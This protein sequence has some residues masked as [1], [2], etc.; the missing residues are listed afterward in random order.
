MPAKGSGK[1]FRVKTGT[2]NLKPLAF[3]ASGFFI[4]GLPGCVFMSG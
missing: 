3:A 1:V 2:L 4:Y